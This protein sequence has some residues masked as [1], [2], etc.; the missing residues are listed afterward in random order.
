MIKLKRCQVMECPAEDNIGEPCVCGCLLYHR[1]CGWTRLDIPCTF[2]CTS[3]PTYNSIPMYPIGPLFFLLISSFA[4]CIRHTSVFSMQMVCDSRQGSRDH[5]AIGI[6][7][8]HCCC[9]VLVVWGPFPPPSRIHNV[10]SVRLC[11]YI[12]GMC[13]PTMLQ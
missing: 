10:P 6:A 2:V 5:G 12:T 11:M 9:L 4:H 1:F 8:G 7:G 3:Y 13:S